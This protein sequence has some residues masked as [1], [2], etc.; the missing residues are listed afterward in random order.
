MTTSPTR[1]TAWSSLATGG[2]S[3]LG[4]GTGITTIS[5]LADCDPFEMVYP[6]RTCLSIDATSLTRIVSWPS[7]A[8]ATP[9]PAS[10]VTDCTTRMPPPGS[11]S[12]ESTFTST[13][14]PLGSSATSRTATGGRSSFDSGSTSM[15]TSPGT[16]FGPAETRYWA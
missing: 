2:R 7:T 9:A 5:P 1:T 12:F 10:T 13:S 8:A 15:R 14:P 11:V 3:V 16:E 4:A 6:I